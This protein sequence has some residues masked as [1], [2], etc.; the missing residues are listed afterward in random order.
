MIAS[1]R[2]RRGQLVGAVRGLVLRQR[3]RVTG[4][5]RLMVEA[6]VRAAA[7]SDARITLSDGLLHLGARW[8]HFAAL[9][10][11]LKLDSGAAIT[12]TGR[13]RLHTGFVCALAPGARLTLGSGY[14]NYR[15]TIDCFADIR[16]GDRVAIGPDVVIRDSDNHGLAVGGPAT[17]PVMI[18]DDVWIGQRAMILKGVTIGDGA[19]VAAG[20]VVTRDVAPRSLVGGVPARVLRTEV[21][22]Q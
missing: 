19:V 16:I 7:A 22:W 1:L 20:A 2:A 14:M 15:G 12:V 8:P 10:C 6:G 21:Q 4:P 13:F 18:G 3:V 9:P 17:A 11:V 5:G